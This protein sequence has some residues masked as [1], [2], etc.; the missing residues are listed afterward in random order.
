[1][2]YAA[3]LLLIAISASPVFQPTCVPAPQPLHFSGW[4]RLYPW[5]PSSSFSFSSCSSKSHRLR[6]EQL[7]IKC[8]QY[9]IMAAVNYILTGLNQGFPR[10][11]D[12]STLALRFAGFILSFFKHCLIA[13]SLYFQICCLL[14]N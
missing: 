8:F 3:P 9:L 14:V 12:I 5:Q 1:M 4:T 13:L 6:L 2:Y 11:L 10:F 7:Q